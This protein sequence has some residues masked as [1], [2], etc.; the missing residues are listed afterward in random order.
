MRV[1]VIIPFLQPN[2]ELLRAVRSVENQTK[3]PHECIPVQ[4]A[5]KQ[6]PAHPR[7]HGIRQAMGDL[8]LCLDSDDWI[9]P[10]FLE[11]TVPMMMSG[12]GIVSTDMRYF[13]GRD[14]LIETYERGYEDQI[15]ENKI[16]CC[17]LFRRDA[18]TGGYDATLPGWEDWDLWLQILKQG[19]KHRVVPEP[20]FNYNVHQG[21]MSAHADANKEALKKRM[22][23]KY[24]EFL[25]IRKT[26]L[27]WNGI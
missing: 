20:L 26:G 27:T 1:S 6:G 9:A 19:W 11:R 3:K 18:L 7:N 5:L 8:I 21:G 10:T 13:G 23:E 22:G 14:L 15:R 2:E 25:E 16:P 24:P 4:D 17:S 12:V